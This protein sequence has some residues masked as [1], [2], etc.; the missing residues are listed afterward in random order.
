MYRECRR[1]VLGGL[2]VCPGIVV[3]LSRSASDCGSAPGRSTRLP[4]RSVLTGTVPLITGQL[5]TAGRWMVPHGRQADQG[6]MQS[7]AAIYTDSQTVVGVCMQSVGDCSW[8]RESQS[9]E[10]QYSY[11]V[12]DLL[13]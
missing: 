3:C 7:G 8:W 13:F 1:S 4:S 2:T 12:K 6:R 10:I 9:C 11:G 5:A